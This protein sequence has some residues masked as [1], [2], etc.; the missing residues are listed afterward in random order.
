MI[1]IQS[2]CSPSSFENYKKNKTCLSIN[3]LRTIATAYNH[4]VTESRKKDKSPSYLKELQS[5]NIKIQIIPFAKFKNIKLLYNALNDRFVA[6]CGEKNDQCWIDQP[7]IKHN[8][9]NIQRVLLSKK[10]RPLMDEDWEKNDHEFVDTVSIYNVMKQY[11]DYYSD[12]ESLGAFPSNFMKRK[13]KEDSGQCK[14]DKVCHFSLSDF[15]LKGKKHLGIVMNFDPNY[16]KGSHWVCF[17]ANF[18]PSDVRYGFY[19]YDSYGLEEHKAVASFYNLLKTQLNDL[20][21]N[22]SKNE[23]INALFKED[24][25]PDNMKKTLKS[26]RIFSFSRNTQR[27]QLKDSECGMFSIVTLVLCIEQKK[28][29]PE[30]IQKMLFSGSDD[31]VHALRKKL[32]RPR[33]YK[34][35]K[36]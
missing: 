25:L 18:D 13:S 10:F 20:R 8:I 4:I 36:S 7:L 21:N 14:I 3:E 9:D 23:E 24:M 22:W 31:T 2:V 5:Q 17:Y 27:H 28:T 19:Y 16:K 12:F 30:I 35:Y 11:E 6:V 1:E 33:I 26:K 29:I 34:T 15:L 32:F